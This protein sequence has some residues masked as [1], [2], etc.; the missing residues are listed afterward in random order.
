[1]NTTLL[2]ELIQD[3]KQYRETFVSIQNK[4]RE[5]TAFIHNPLQEAL[6]K[7]LRLGEWVI[8][9]K[10]RQMGCSTLILSDFHIQCTTI[11]NT[12]ASVVSHEEFATQRLL[13]KVKFFESSVPE[14]VKPILNH[15]SS[16]ELTWPS[17][18]SIFYIGSARSAV[19]GRGDTI[20]LLHFSE[21]AWFPPDKA[22]MLMVGA[23]E[24]VPPSGQLIWE[25]TPN[26]RVGPFY[27]TYQEA[28]AGEN[29]FTPLFFPWW[30]DPTYSEPE[31]SMEV[32][33]K[34]RYHIEPD[35]EEAELM[36]LHNLTIGQI[37]WRQNKKA[38]LKELF[39]QEYP[40]N[41][42]DCW[43]VKG[44]AALPVEALLEM[45]ARVRKPLSDVEGVRVW[46]PAS[47]GQKYIIAVD[48]A[49]GLPTSDNSV[50]VVLDREC[51]HVATLRGKFP[52]DVMAT[53][54]VELGRRYHNATVVVEREGYGD[55]VIKFMVRE[56]YTNI[57][58]NPDGR[59]GWHT[60][61]KNRNSMLEEL[62]T[63]I[64]THT[65]TTFDDMFVN[66][67]LDF[68]FIDGK[69][70]AP[71]K[72][73]DDLVMAMAIGVSIRQYP[74]FRGSVVRPRASS[75]VPAGVL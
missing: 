23:Q 43:L 5:T 6:W 46:R 44:Q 47:G 8:I 54:V 33:E 25:S 52:T 4:D 20:H 15:K 59:V 57:W 68:Q 62:S 13:D 56:G 49:K 21:P 41:D 39:K 64:R 7:H 1:M 66:E 63:S 40:E 18:D 24:A 75:Y 38:R 45:A 28:K 42:I 67:A 12:V 74:G 10:A 37:R 16:H 19:I 50:A 55:A 3:R 22:E 9:V 71:P 53:K 32:A 29:R 14:Q 34:Y 65:L 31:G 27:E 35:D 60:T 36:T 69:A 26:G 58:K 48:A 70:Q 72:G 11:P 73:H 2:K 51:N 30:F 61:G 17:I